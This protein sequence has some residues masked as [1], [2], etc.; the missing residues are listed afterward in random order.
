[1]RTVIVHLYCTVRHEPT[2]YATV[3]RKCPTDD[4]NGAMTYVKQQAVRL[5]RHTS[6]AL[7]THQLG[8]GSSRVFGAH[9]GNK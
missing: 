5:R 9:D 7:D 3:A 6:V 2:I 4:E 8:R 1:M